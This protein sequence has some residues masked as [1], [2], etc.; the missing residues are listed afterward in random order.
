MRSFT[1]G[2]SVHASDRGSWHPTPLVSVVGVSAPR[3]ELCPPR[4]MLVVDA[5]GQ[6]KRVEPGALIRAR[7]AGLP[8][9][10][11]IV[12]ETTRLYDQASGLLMKFVAP[13]RREGLDVRL[14]RWSS[15]AARWI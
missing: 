8:W 5:G 14:S 3:C 6:T 2:D 7:A 12:V 11:T 9:W 15:G 13:S 10:R 4:S 1:C